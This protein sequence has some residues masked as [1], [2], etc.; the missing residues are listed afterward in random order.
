MDFRHRPR[1]RCQNLE[2][3]MSARVFLGLYDDRQGAN[4][5]GEFTYR[6]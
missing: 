5:H 4:F 3:H 1:K 6:T 2:R